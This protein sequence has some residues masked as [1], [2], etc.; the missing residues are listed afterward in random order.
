MGVEGE[1]RGV[2][3]RKKEE[4]GEEEEEVEEKKEANPLADRE[5][6]EAERVEKFRSRETWRKVWAKPSNVRLPAGQ[7]WSEL[8]SKGSFKVA[9]A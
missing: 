1:E 2:K 4:E 9:R 8:R 6:R 3:G 5:S 7:R